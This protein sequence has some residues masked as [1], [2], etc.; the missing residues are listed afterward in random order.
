VTEADRGELSA[1]ITVRRPALP[2]SIAVAVLCL[3]GT[4]SLPYAY[5]EFLR[6]SVSAGALI[7]AAIALTAK[8]PW[9]IA[10]SVLALVVYAPIGRTFFNPT[11]GG[12]VVADLATA[13]FFVLAGTRIPP[14]DN[15]TSS[16]KYVNWWVYTLAC[17]SIVLLSII[18]ASAPSR[19]AVE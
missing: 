15:G 12:W 10:P 13:A 6:A 17:V 19:P 8:R 9:W 18:L 5:Y 11:Q 7:V 3:I 4:A 1:S 2:S 14:M 16:T